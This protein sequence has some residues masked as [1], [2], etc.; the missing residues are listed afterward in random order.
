M[1]TKKSGT[2]PQAVSTRRANTRERLMDAGLAVFAERGVLAASVEQVCDRAGFTRGA[3]YSNFASKDELCLSILRRESQT[4]IAAASQ[5]LAS[6]RGP[7]AGEDPV[8][9]AVDT[10]MRFQRASRTGVLA[11]LEMRLHAARQPEVRTAYLAQHDQLVQVFV[12][13]VAEGVELAGLRL[14]VPVHTL[15]RNLGAVYEHTMLLSL[16]DGRPG[17]EV[18]RDA[19]VELVKS[20]CHPA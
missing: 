20:L 3:F 10:F 11:S 4:H 18:T 16:V 1:R 2:A 12:G 13:V 15:V 14:R 5:A 6:L 8:T 19:L 9:E 17:P 7:A